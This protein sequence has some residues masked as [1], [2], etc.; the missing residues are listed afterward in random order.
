MPNDET[1]S[2]TNDHSRTPDPAG[3]AVLPVG[4]V[5]GA[6]SGGFSGFAEGAVGP[7]APGAGLFA[8]AGPGGAM[9]EPD[10]SLAGRIEETLA[11]DGRIGAASLGT[12]RVA[13]AGGVVSLSG[14][15]AHD[16]ERGVIADICQHL[17]GVVR[18]ENH[19]AVA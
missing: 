6:A 15:V 1:T 19:L 5:L 10:Q 12:L 17:P 2:S 18:V 16:H 3:E 13:V 9:T 11:E 8:V 7:L 4:G 14:A